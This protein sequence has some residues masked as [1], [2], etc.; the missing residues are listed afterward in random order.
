[1]ERERDFI[2]GHS[3]YA[4]SSQRGNALS[5]EL[6][7]GLPQIGWQDLDYLCYHGCISRKLKQEQ[8]QVSNPGSQLW[9][10]GVLTGICRVGQ[11][12]T[13]E[14]QTSMT[15]SLKATI[16]EVCPLSALAIEMS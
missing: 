13:L 7:P 9:A 5:W 14:K 4:H 1:M 3:L 12:P 8:S 6:S 10:A 16:P 15:S 11:T 2:L